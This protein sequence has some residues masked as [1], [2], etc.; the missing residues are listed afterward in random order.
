MVPAA[1][2]LLGFGIFLVGMC[3]DEDRAVAGGFLL[4]LVSWGIGQ[5]MHRGGL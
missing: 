3:R 1:T 4:M 2:C 5:A